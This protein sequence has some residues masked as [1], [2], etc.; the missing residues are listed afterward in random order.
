[1]SERLPRTTLYGRH[2]A[3]ARDAITKEIAMTKLGRVSVE[4]LS[5]KV[6]MSQ[7]SDTDFRI[8]L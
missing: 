3:M 7:E 1:L 6:N 5:Q 2:H 8:T 4:T